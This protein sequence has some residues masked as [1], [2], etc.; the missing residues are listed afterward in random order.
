VERDT[1]VP[2][3]QAEDA[4]TA[5]KQKQDDISNAEKTGLTT[6]KPGTTFDEMLNAIG[7][8]FSDLASSDD[9]EDREDDDEDGEDAAGGKLSEDDDTRWVISTHSKTVQYCMERF[10]QKQRKLYESTQPGWGDGADYFRERDK[11]YGMTELK[12]AAVV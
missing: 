1:A 9:G 7:D 11:K 8:S 2:K 4:E 12:V 10:R 6:T 5:I 3:K